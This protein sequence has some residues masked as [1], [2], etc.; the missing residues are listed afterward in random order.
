VETALLESISE[1]VRD[2]WA[3]RGYS[4]VATNGWVSGNAVCCIHN[5][6]TQD[7]RGRG[8]FI[9]SP[10]G[11]VAWH[12]FN[13]G[14]KTGYHPGSHLGFRF[15]RLLHW[16]GADRNEIQ[17]LVIEAIRIREITGL[18]TKTEVTGFSEPEYPVIELPLG[19]VSLDQR[20]RESHF[21]SH[22]VSMIEYATARRIN[23]DPEDPCH[24]DLYTNQSTEHNLNQRIIVPFYWRGSLVGYTA[25]DITGTVSPKYHSSQPGDYVFNLDR[26][27]KDSS[28]V[29][30]CEGVFDAM[31]IDAVA[32]L[33]AEA[34]DT[35]V[36]IIDSLGKTVI[37][38]PDFDRH[39][40]RRG[41]LVWPGGRL[42]DAAMEYGWSVSFPAWAETCKDINQAVCK[43]G[44]LF[45]V[46]DILKNTHSNALKIQLKKRLYE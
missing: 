29:F 4:R 18:V 12:C 38:V 5:G 13:C 40:N 17:R 7:T 27:A 1:T 2:L 15:R 37:L 20:I 46:H 32:L 31:S 33:K 14:F 16:L 42:V 41:R 22:T 11:G 36:D 30:V 44:R 45:V 3:K 24:Y 25:R 26:Q 10:D 39:A 34:S 9:F 23:I 28:V 43:Y 35:Q 6:E 8:G 19:T 21:D